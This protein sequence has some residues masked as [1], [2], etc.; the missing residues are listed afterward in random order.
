MFETSYVK[1]KKKK[2]L[3]LVML[4]WTLLSSISKTVFFPNTEE[5]FLLLSIFMLFSL[6]FFFFGHTACAFR[7]RR[8]DSSHGSPSHFRIDW[9]KS[10]RR[11]PFNK[12]FSHFGCFMKENGG[13]T[14]EQNNHEIYPQSW[15]VHTPKVEVM[16]GGGEKWEHSNA[17]LNWFYFKTSWCHTCTCWWPKINLYSCCIL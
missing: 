1:K 11:L 7:V 8:I 12:D 10:D 15:L 13:K 5:H 2:H 6:F 9:H 16:L 14:C 17:K 3:C 4:L